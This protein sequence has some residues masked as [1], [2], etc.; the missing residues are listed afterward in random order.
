[1]NR[2]MPSR[3]LS[4]A[5][6]AVLILGASASAAAQQNVTSA[7]TMSAQGQ[8]PTASGLTIAF[9][10][11]NADTFK[12]EGD[13]LTANYTFA[14]A[15]GDAEHNSV[16]TWYINGTSTGKTG[17]TYTIPA[18]QAGQTISYQ[19]QVKTD[20]TI[21]DPAEGERLFD[22]A[23]S[24]DNG[25]GQGTIITSPPSTNLAVRIDLAGT[26]TRPMVGKTM[27]ATLTCAAGTDDACGTDV[28][29]RWKR[30]L[31]TGGTWMS[32]PGAAGGGKTYTVTKDDQLYIF[33]V[34]VTRNTR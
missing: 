29:Y 30:Q 13:T 4:R 18:Y 26:D 23:N 20:A 27:T 8:A 15:D 25:G 33:Q 14:D 2:I 16:I 12:N 28:N 17:Q 7:P 19:V 21:T 6:V 11:T 32:I 5:C 3:L 10:D 9:T 1:M 31:S 22:S 34:Q 24:T